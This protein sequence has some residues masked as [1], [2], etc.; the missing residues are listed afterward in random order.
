MPQLALM[1]GKPCIAREFRPYNSM[2]EEEAAAAAGVVRSGVLSGFHGSWNDKFYGG[3]QVRAFEKA[4]AEF[5]GVRH[6]VSLNSWTSGLVAAVGAA[7][8][9]PGDEVIV[10]PWTMS[11]T[12]TA[13]VAWNGIP[14]F[15]DIDR[16]TFNLDPDSVRRCLSPRTKAI[17]VPDIFGQGAEVDALMEIA[18]EKGLLLIEDAAQAPFARD[19]GRFVGTLGHMGGYSLNYHKHIHTGEGGMLVTDDDGWAEH[20]RM[21]RNHGEV[22]AGQKP[23]VDLT[24]MIGFNLRMGEIEAAIGLVQLRKL[25][26][27]AEAKTHVGSELNRLLAGMPGLCPP[28]VRPGCTHVYYV[29]GLRVETEQLG[30]TRDAL[31]A[32]L[33]AEGVPTLMR[34]YQLIHLL[35]MYQQRRAYGSGHFPWTTT[36]DPSLRYARGTC[37]VAEHLHAQ[38]LIGLRT[39]AFDFDAGD[40]AALAGA[41]HKVWENLDEVRAYQRGRS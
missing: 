37:P 41:F 28:R 39:C 9:G 33:Q 34:G 16:D 20:V 31:V 19:Q 35:P 15:A 12:A 29:Y 4:W 2:G 8:I 14:V 6:A 17:V 26:A 7:R 13:I 10:S 30:V 24:N 1:G 38:E 32:A 27:L 25:P 40:C 11:A 18:R 5:F 23:G 3:P 21:I 36:D 22:I